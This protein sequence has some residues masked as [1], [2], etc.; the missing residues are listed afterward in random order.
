MQYNWNDETEAL[1]SA[2]LMTKNALDDF[3]IIFSHKGIILSFPDSLNSV[4][5][6]LELKF[7]FLF[8][9]TFTAMNDF[10]IKLNLN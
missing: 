1:R 5:M 2:D 9:F 4:E 7:W 3:Y 6:N 10:N 8:K